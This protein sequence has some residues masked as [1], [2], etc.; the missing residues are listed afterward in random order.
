M[1]GQPFADFTWRTARQIVAGRGGDDC[2]ETAIARALDDLLTRAGAGPA[3]SPPAGDHVRHRRVAA[4]TRAAVRSVLPPG[5]APDDVDDSV[6]DDASLA[7]VI[8]FGIFEP[9]DERRYR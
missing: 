3:E 1:V 4:R 7:T 2:D 6:E 5:E 9:G 8:P